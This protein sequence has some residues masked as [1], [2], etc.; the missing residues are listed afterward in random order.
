MLRKIPETIN[1]YDGIGIALRSRYIGQKS[2]LAPYI[3]AELRQRH[4]ETCLNWG[5]RERKGPPRSTGQCRL[6]KEVEVAFD[7]EISNRS[8]KIQAVNG[9]LV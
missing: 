7:T 1:D 6:G 3:F 5:A 4:G 9:R 8:G 2:P